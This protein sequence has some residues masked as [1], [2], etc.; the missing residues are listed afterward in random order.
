M[1]N[2]LVGGGAGTSNNSF[3]N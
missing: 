1:T 3:L 2:T